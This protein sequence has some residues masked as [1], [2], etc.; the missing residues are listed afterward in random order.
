MD[1]ADRELEKML[2]TS[3]E[4]AKISFVSNVVFG[5]AESPREL[6]TFSTMFGERRKEGDD[7]S[8]DEDQGED[9]E[10]EEK[11]EK[12]IPQP[13]NIVK[14]GGTEI[15]LPN[16]TM[17]GIAL[18]NCVSLSLVVKC[19]RCKSLVEI[20]AISFA[21]TVSC[22]KCPSQI[23]CVFTPVLCHAGNNYSIGSV[24]VTGGITVDI[25]ASTYYPT[26]ESCTRENRTSSVFRYNLT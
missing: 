5:S 15:R 9:A 10:H 6:N 7:S 21:T 19:T 22:L 4:P 20:K 24:D 23:A 3:L 13:A 14:R 8:D 18:I 16:P 11:E 17:K 2:S 26:C 1:W 12:A 25:L